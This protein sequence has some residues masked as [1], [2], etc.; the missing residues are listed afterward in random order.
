MDPKGW[1]MTAAGIVWAARGRYVVCSHPFP[2]TTP[3]DRASSNV[4]ETTARMAV[5][6]LILLIVRNEANE[7]KE[8]IEKEQKE[9]RDHPNRNDI[10]HQTLTSGTCF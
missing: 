3:K 6:R 5:V 7:Q 4:S 10:I 9:A 2:L 1:S 8:A